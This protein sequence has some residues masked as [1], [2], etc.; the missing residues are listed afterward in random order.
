ML[1]GK[2]MPSSVCID[3]DLTL[4]D[5]EGK[6]LPGAAEALKRLRAAGLSLTLWSMGGVAYAKDVAA[7]HG[8][9][10]YFDGFAAKPDA[11]ID[12]DLESFVPQLR[13]QM[14]QDTNWS[15][16]VERVLSGFANMDGHPEDR[17]RLL[18][19]IEKCQ[20]EFSQIQ[21]AELRVA[22]ADRILPVPELG[23]PLHPIPFFGH[24]FGAEILTMG[25]NPSWTE[26]DS[27]RSW[28]GELDVKGLLSRL[29]DYFYANPHEWFSAFDKALLFLERSYLRNAAHV[30][31][32]PYPTKWL[33]EMGDSARARFGEILVAHST[34]HLTQTLGLCR[35]A[36]LIMIRDYPLSRV[37][38]GVH[39][40]FDMITRC[41]PAIRS[42]VRNNGSSPPI[43]RLP[44]GHNL[45]DAIY[46]RR[47]ELIGFLSEAS[48]LHFA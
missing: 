29:F 22:P 35:N 41:C 24:P 34:N 17:A 14:R 36:K 10:G 7:R 8:I 12:D 37:A 18:S 26:F 33:K 32:F 21:Q 6:L 30:D 42:Q 40:T 47:R 16:L 28:P 46:D 39:S 43:L 48:P 44:A 19:N 38:E 31:L 45:S 9:E 11:V 4:I 1:K 2:R 15:E 25:L 20:K 5:K 27:E 3:V 23:L 13:F